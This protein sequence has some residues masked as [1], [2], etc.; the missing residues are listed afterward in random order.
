MKLFE[1]FFQ[2]QKEPWKFYE[3]YSQNNISYIKQIPLKQ[4]FFI[5]TNENSNYKHLLTEENLRRKEGSSKDYE[6]TFGTINPGYRLLRDEYWD[7]E[8]PKYNFNPKIWYLDIE[9]TAHRPVDAENCYERIVLI[10]IFDSQLK[11]CFVLG[12]EDFENYDKF[13]LNDKTYDFKVRYLK[14]KDERNILENYFKLVEKLDPLYVFAW[15]GEGFDFSYL[16][17]RAIKNCLEPKFSKYG[18]G[19]LKTEKFSNGKSVYRLEAPGIFYIDFI[20]IYKKYVFAPRDSYAL[21][22]IAKIEVNE[23]KVNHSCFSTFDGFRTG[24]DYIIPSERP[25]DGFEA[26]IYDAYKNNDLESAFKISHNMFIKYGIIDTYLLYLIDDKLKLSFTMLML[27]SLMGVNGKDI[28]GTTKPWSQLIQN[29]TY[30]QNKITPDF[31][32]KKVDVS[33]KGG[34]VPNPQKGKVKDVFSVD[35]NSAYPLLSMCGFNMSPET[36]VPEHKI[37]D[38]LKDLRDTLFNDEDEQRRYEDYKSGKL[39]D[40]SNLLKKYNLSCGINGAFFKKDFDGIVP[41]LVSK[42]Y[43]S[44]KAEKKNMLKAKQDYE[45]T[46]DLKYKEIE[47]VSNVKQMAFKILINSLYGALG[48]QYFKLFNL[49]IAR[50]ITGNTRFYIQILGNNINNYLQSIKQ[51]DRSY[52]TY[53]DTDSVVGSSIINVNNNKIKIEDYYNSIHSD[54]IITSNNAFIKKVSGDVTTTVNN[55]FKL[56]SNN[57]KYVMKHRV[58]K[59]MFKISVNNKEVIVTE[60]HSIMV[61]RNDKLISVKPKDIVEGDELI[62][63]E[64]DN[65]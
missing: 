19:E 45:D 48:N 49:E 44:R 34:F 16:Y 54:E 11:T 5:P 64:G 21:D 10:Q 25:T 33:I 8:N 60:D 27:S 22:N 17:N 40:F 53:S 28:M 59:R 31:E 58:K 32:D 38:D 42:F 24:K 2:D 29:F 62:V 7:L 47:T 30:K 9:T 4:E 41:Q 46:K 52:W 50:A 23:Q 12:L 26:K 36:Y 15:N 20:D 61:K 43:S 39:N 13:E 6:K 35:I 37:P 3:R 51:R 55:D 57:I 14:C 65:R 1:C 18:N 56:E 63:N